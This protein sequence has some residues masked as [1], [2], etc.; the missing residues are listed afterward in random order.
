MNATVVE[1][2]RGRGAVVVSVG[3]ESCAQAV[4][5]AKEAERAGADAVMAIP[6]LASALSE[7]ESER[8]F[9][10][11]ADAVSLPVV[12]Q[13]ASGYVGRPLSLP[14]QMRLFRDYGAEKIL[15]KPETC[16]SLV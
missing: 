15:F 16:P 13:D 5:F 6:P 9:R 11:I 4:L 8:Y 10:S 14:M 12:I 1:H 3:A 2:V 7:S